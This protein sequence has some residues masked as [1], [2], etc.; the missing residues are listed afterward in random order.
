MQVAQERM[1][2]EEIEKQNAKTTPHKPTR[3]V[4]ISGIKERLENEKAF[5]VVST[6]LFLG[7]F[8]DI[9]NADLTISS[10]DTS[11]CRDILKGS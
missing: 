2:L 5:L 11:C 4:V 9:F 3:S 8:H 7:V 1:K 10:S 6:D